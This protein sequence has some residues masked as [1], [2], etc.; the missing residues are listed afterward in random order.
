MTKTAIHE[1]GW[2]TRDQAA[3]LI[4]SGGVI[5]FRTDTFYGLGADP[6][7]A[8]AVQR[9]RELKGREE[10]NPILVLVSDESEIDRFLETSQLFRDVAAGHWPGPLTLVGKA[11]SSVPFQL[12]ANTET[13]GVRLP[14]AEDVR[15]LVRCCGGALTA[16]SANIS[17]SPPA[18]T[19][20]EVAAYFPSGVDL[21]IDS[22]EVVATEPSTVL[23]VNG[24]MARLIREGAVSREALKEFF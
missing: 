16:T 15:E 7:N 12:T 6:L 23:D 14:A 24:R 17:G 10:S 9:V 20:K 18:R 22:G 3:K 19:A 21:I 5:A 8:S 13:L 4:K 1:D 2:Q 11:K